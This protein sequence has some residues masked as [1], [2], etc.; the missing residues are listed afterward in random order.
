MGCTNLTGTLGIRLAEMSHSV[1]LVLF[2]SVVLACQQDRME[3]ADLA[4]VGGQV[5]TLTS[6][7]VVEAVAVRDW[8]DPGY[9]NIF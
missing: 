9:W 6:E 5:I 1:L 8:Q 3:L 4:L 7:G 2:V